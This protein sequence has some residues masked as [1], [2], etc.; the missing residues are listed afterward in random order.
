MEIDPRARAR[1]ALKGYPAKPE[2]ETFALQYGQDQTEERA[3]TKFS[4]WNQFRCVLLEGIEIIDCSPLRRGSVDGRPESI[5]P[6]HRATEV[7]P[8]RPARAHSAVGEQ[9]G[10]EVPVSGLPC[11]SG[12]LVSALPRGPDLGRTQLA[13]GH[14]AERTT[15]GTSRTVGVVGGWARQASCT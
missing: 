13:G 4:L 5:T 11:R 3:V 12:S 10:F 8:A 2:T 6:P 1:Q 14:A 7:G 15:L 9:T